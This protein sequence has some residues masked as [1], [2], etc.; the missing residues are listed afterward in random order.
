MLSNAGSLF[1]I[2]V[3]F[4]LLNLFAFFANV[5]GYFINTFTGNIFDK[6]HGEILAAIDVNQTADVLGFVL[7]ELALRYEVT[8]PKT[9]FPLT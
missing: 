2:G 3:S 5:F 6:Y 9:S 4:L 1:V 7:D 8:F